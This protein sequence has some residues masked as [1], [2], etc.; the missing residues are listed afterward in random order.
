MTPPLRTDRARHG[1]GGASSTAADIPAF[2]SVEHLF[3]DASHAS[4]PEHFSREWQSSQAFRLQHGELYLALDALRAIFRGGAAELSASQR[5]TL[6]A[7]RRVAEANAG[8]VEAVVLENLRR[9]LAAAGE[10]ERA[11]AQAVS[12]VV[13]EAPASASTAGRGGDGGFRVSAITLDTHF[14]DAALRPL[15][16]YYTLG[17]LPREGLNQSQNTAFGAALGGEF[18]IGE[19]NFFLNGY[20]GYD[21]V[22]DGNPAAHFNRAALRFGMVEYG[23]PFVGRRGEGFHLSLGGR[24]RAGIGVGVGWCDHIDGAATSGA[25]CSSPTFQLLMVND[26]DLLSA[27]YGPFELGIRLLPATAAL[28]FGPDGLASMNRLPLEFGL[29]WHLVPPQIDAP[30]QDPESVF[31]RRVTT[32]EIVFTGLNLFDNA[33]IA[34]FRRQQEAAYEGTRIVLLGMPFGAAASASQYS[35]LNT[36]SFFNGVLGGLAEGQMAYRLH[37]QLRH[38]DLGQRLALAGMLGLEFAINGIGALA[39]PADPGRPAMPGAMGSP[40]NLQG[41]AFQLAWP[42]L[43]ARDALATL[44]AVGAFG[45]R[46]EAIRSNSISYFHV[47]HGV[48]ALGGLV[49]I[50]TSGDGTGT[51]FFGLSLLGNTPPNTPRLEVVGS[52]YDYPNQ[53]FEYFRLEAGTMLLTYGINGILDWGLNRLA[54]LNLLDQ[55][56]RGVESG[57]GSTAARSPIS[58][59]LSTDWQ[60]HVT[61]TVSGTF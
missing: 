12:A 3:R 41:Q 27:G 10:A 40:A 37:S 19:F 5:D 46:N 4:D 59:S 53:R 23:R 17:I 24:N 22:P 6:A 55:R 43:L 30:N 8:S 61:G 50:L 29:T 11:R 13:G 34:N 31:R 15:P 18:R 51:G 7:L 9:G 21:V 52:P 25:T 45:D 1:S 56:R 32:P 36:G 42:T 58:V 54:Y 38:G 39:M 20:F 33:I 49:M 48:L 14:A 44:G 16:S 26:S 28:N 60:T 47:A 35:L 2:L 57:G